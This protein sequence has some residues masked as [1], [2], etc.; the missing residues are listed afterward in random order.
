MPVRGKPVSINRHTEAITA[1]IGGMP[2]LSTQTLH[3]NQKY[4]SRDVLDTSCTATQPC[5]YY[6]EVPVLTN[7]D[8]D[9][10]MPR[11]KGSWLP[12]FVLVSISFSF[13]FFVFP[14]SLPS[15]PHLSFSD[16]IAQILPVTTFL[17]PNTP[18]VSNGRTDQVQWDNY[19][20]ILRGQRVLI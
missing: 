2:V 15:W 11:R 1:S 4:S 7:L 14:P 10:V 20:L 6:D 9:T 3:E 12:I 18:A 17:T 16:V 8:H 19:S 5:S 13:I